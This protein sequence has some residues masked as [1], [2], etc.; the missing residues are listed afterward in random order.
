MFIFNCECIAHINDA[1]CLDKCLKA[2]WEKSD[3]L[4][5]H[6]LKKELLEQEQ[7][8]LNKEEMQ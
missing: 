4:E 3:L 1:I 7:E 5:S 6:Q 8:A 2:P